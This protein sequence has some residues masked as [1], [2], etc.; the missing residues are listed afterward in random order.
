MVPAAVQKEL[1]ASLAY[2]AWL[3]SWPGAVVSVPNTS[4]ALGVGGRGCVDVVWTWSDVSDRVSETYDNLWGEL[5]FVMHDIDHLWRANE[6]RADW[7]ESLD[8]GS[9]LRVL[10]LGCGNGI[11]DIVLARRGHAVVG[12]DQVRPVIE[13]GRA[14]V[15]DEPV[16]FRVGDLRSVAFEPAQFDVVMM[17]GLA[18]LMSREDDEAL[19]HRVRTWLRPGGSCL[20]DC[21]L[22]LAATETIE[23]NHELGKIYWHWTSDETTRTNRL[24]P[25]L[26]R[27]DGVIVELRDPIDP[28]RGDHTGLHRHIYPMDELERL[29]YGAGFAPRRVDHFLEHV[30]PESDPDAY[31]LH[32]TTGQTI[33]TGFG[34]GGLA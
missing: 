21:D 22:E 24:T 33:Q 5:M 9:G 23:S 25:E 26:H 34:L 28:S 16:T 10:D 14:H 17:F 29:L 2:F 31:M 7:V 6:G 8:L 19:F 32:A 1:L 15:N 12:V 4:R 20:V 30:F 27:R 18:G 13:F 3:L 11:L